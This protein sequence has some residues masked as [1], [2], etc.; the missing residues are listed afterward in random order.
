MYPGLPF[1]VGEGAGTEWKPA[2]RLGEHN[3]HV[4]QELLGLDDATIQE[5]SDRGI[6]GTIP[7]PGKQAY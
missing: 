6:M 4:F 2:P 1:V 3:G 7:V 5:L